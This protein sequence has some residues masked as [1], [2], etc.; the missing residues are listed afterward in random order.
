MMSNPA[1]QALDALTSHN[2]VDYSLVPAHLDE[3]DTVYGTP[4]VY[5]LMLKQQQQHDDEQL[6]DDAVKSTTHDVANLPPHYMDRSIIPFPEKL[7]E[8]LNDES[9]P[10]DIISWRPHGRSFK[11]ERAD[12]FCKN[13]MSKFFRQSKYTSFTRQLNL[14]G[15]RR[16]TCGTDAGS[17][18]HEFFLRGLPHLAHRMRRVRVKG[19]GKKSKNNPCTEPDFYALDTLRPLPN[20]STG[21]KQEMS[22]QQQLHIYPDPFAFVSSDIDIM[23][24]NSSVADEFPVRASLPP[25]PDNSHDFKLCSTDGSPPSN[26]E[27]SDTDKDDNNLVTVECSGIDEILRVDFR[28]FND[29]CDIDGEA[30]GKHPDKKFA[31]NS[32]LR[33]LDLAIRKSHDSRI[34]LMRTGL[35][36]GNAFQL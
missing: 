20:I 30:R 4:L 27:E 1:Q 31:L 17:Y 13:I 26:V 3:T 11:V 35:L 6:L 33:R 8:I 23:R 22:K 29:A 9:V 16:I 28:G 7:L 24:M 14:W 21:Q 25:T 36:D 19:T 34:R 10:P 32:Q 18:Y 12:L 15:F 5:L 2:Y